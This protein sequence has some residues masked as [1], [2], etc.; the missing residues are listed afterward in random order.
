MKQRS[1]F[2]WI[3]CALLFFATTINYMDRQILGLLKPTLSKDLGWSEADYGNV[4][5]CFQFAYGIGQF[6]FG[7]LV[8]II[9]TKLGFTMAI[10]FWSIAIAGHSL[11]HSVFGFGAWRVA[12]VLGEAGNFPTAI[13]CVAEWFPKKERALATGIF[14]SGSNVG[15]IFAPVLVPWLA[16]QFGWRMSFVALGGAG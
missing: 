4:V 14:N 3:V 15:A 1:N 5:S 2:R 8:D 11:A 10:I 13:K 9:G 16:S 7:R 6:I 12:L